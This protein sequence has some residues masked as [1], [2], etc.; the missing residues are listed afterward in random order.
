MV[1]VPV[2]GVAVYVGGAAFFA[3]VALATVFAAREFSCLFV[4]RGFRPP[5]QVAMLLAFA[6]VVE[7]QM[8]DRGSGAVLAAAVLLPL[9]WMLFRQR[10]LGG[11]LV[12][13]ALSV[14][15]ALYVGW[16][17]GHFLSL[18]AVPGGSESSPVPEGAIWVAL[19]LAGT[20]A[21]DTGAYF[22]GRRWG[23]HKLYSRI[24]PGKTWEGTIGGLALSAIIVP[25]VGRPML[26]LPWAHAVALGMVIGVA[27]ILGDLVESMMKRATDAKDTGR[28][29]PGHGGLLDRLDSLIFAV[30]A[31]Y[32]YIVAFGFLK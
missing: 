1:M 24:S 2:V 15:G 29:I 4:A 5:H 6:F 32:Y 25:L 20:W 13:W 27:A 14:A 9:V 3:L 23:C 10:D 31:A 11:G 21:C 8:G 30:V 12:G 22:V 26:A 17:M 7:A 18:R 28:L 16:P 19:V